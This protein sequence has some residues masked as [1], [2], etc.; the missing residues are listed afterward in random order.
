ATLTGL[1]LD[2]TNA[3]V[4][5][6]G[7]ATLSVSG[8]LGLA[9]LKPANPLTD[10]R[11][12]FALKMGDVTVSGGLD[13]VA[14]GLQLS[15]DITIGQFDYNSSSSGGVAAAPK[16][17]DWARAFDLDGD[18]QFDDALNP[19]ADLPVAQDLTI[20][21]ASSLQV[22]LNG[23]LTGTG[24]VGAPGSG[25]GNPVDNAILT[26]GPLQVTGTAGFALT[27]S[28]VD[29]DL[30]GNGTADLIGATL[31]GLALDVTNAGVNI[32]GI[33]TLSVSGKLGLATLKPANPL[34]DT[35]SWFALKMGDVTVSGGLDE[36]ALGLQLS[37]DITIGQ[38]DYNSSSSGGVAAAPKRLDWARA[39]DLDGD[40][41][42][43]DALNPGADLPVAQDL[44]ID[45][46]SSLQVR[47]N[48]T[49]TGT[50]QVG[51]PGSGVGN[52]VDNAIL[53]VG[54]LQVT[55]TAGFALTMSTVDADLDGNGTADLI[56]ATLTGLALDVTNA[57]VNIT[58]IATLSVSGK[59]G[60]ATL[61][62]ANPLT[63]TRSWFALKMGDVT[64][65]GGLDEVALG[66]QLSADITIGQFD[67]N[68][69]SSGGVAAAPKRLD[70]A[71]AFDLDGDGQFDDALN[72]GADLPVAQD[73]TID[74]ASS[75]Q[76][77]LN[78]TLT[79][80]G[81]VGAP[82]SG[83]GNPVDNAIL[84]VGPLQ[85][86]GTAGFALTMSTVDADLDGNGTADLIGATLT[87]LA[88]DVTNAGVN[89]TGIA[90]LSVSGKLGLATL[91]PAN[92]L[93]DTRSW[94]A[95]KM[96]DVTVSGGLDEVA[97]GLQLSADITIGQFDYNSSSSG[98]V[99]AAPKRL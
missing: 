36:V 92:P 69:S 56:G 38:F 93:T 33:A 40:G 68:S 46:A 20:D 8:K 26:V 27:M 25:V 63:D 52:P 47:L 76:V 65:S 62:P 42:F 37:A 41:Q 31:T 34:T 51:A 5:I 66:L 86:T 30:D 98:G 55:G 67:Y 29:A 35:R 9:T 28:T 49:L 75:L 88:L 21:F 1:A 60:L 70:W 14:L 89:I 58:G 43:D 10:T 77:R 4:N 82:G 57:G 64:V 94:F 15:A 2:V 99:A 79:G 18:G 3:G 44:T 54:P 80:T 19:G 73:L 91:K 74:F 39:F 7:I 24:Q 22:R 95:L 61:K 45:F 96:G 6:T 85:V 12:W 50:G 97:L 87:G 72:P 83:L 48:G 13:E 23:T 84:T 11:S 71:R 81:Q 59:L 16:R 78:G 32:T 17:L 90:T 53:T